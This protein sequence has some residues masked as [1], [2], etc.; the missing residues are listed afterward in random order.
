M[1]ERTDMT[2]L[3]VTFRMRKRLI[4]LEYLIPKPNIRCSILNFSQ[5][6]WLDSIVSGADFLS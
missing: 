1:D 3:I 5:V 4:N 6:S 2:K